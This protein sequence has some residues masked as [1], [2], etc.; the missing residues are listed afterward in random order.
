MKR[1][2]CYVFFNHE[3]A[4]GD[5]GHKWV[6]ELASSLLL[7]FLDVLPARPRHLAG[8]LFSCGKFFKMR[9]LLSG[10]LPQKVLQ[11]EE[12]DRIRKSA[13][14]ED[15]RIVIAVKESLTTLFWARVIV[16]EG[17]YNFWLVSNQMLTYLWF[18][19]VFLAQEDSN[20]VNQQEMFWNSSQLYLIPSPNVEL[21]SAHSR[22]FLC[23]WV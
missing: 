20:K 21:L 22:V 14:E 19:T 13:C 1:Q 8:E 7:T 5:E 10:S 11:V 15:C 18:L 23:Y 12:V 3:L 17:T 6:D 4:G 2:Q 16:V 9:S